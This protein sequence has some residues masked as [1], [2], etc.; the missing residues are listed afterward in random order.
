MA[1][2]L[3]LFGFTVNQAKVY[4]AIVEAGSISV[5]K[6]A[7]NTKL[8]RQDIYKI[9]PDLE[10]KGLVTRSLD[11]P[12]LVKPIS[13][14][15]ALTSLVEMKKK[16]ALDSLA[17]MESNLTEVANAVNM[18]YGT[19]SDPALEE[20][21]FCLLTTEKA[22]TVRADI[23]F[24]KAEKECNVVLSTELLM[25]R[26]HKFLERFEKAASNGATIRLIVETDRQDERIALVVQTVRPRNGNFSAKMMI[27][28]SPKPFSVIDGKEVWIATSKKQENSGVYCVLWSTG[29]NIVGIYQDRFER[30]WKSKN[31]LIIP[32][33]PTSREKEYD[34]KLEDTMNP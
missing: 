1:R 20:E 21:G 32:L 7:E 33:V 34:K 3:L 8:H 13:V 26:R 25:A 29:K 6:I 27:T 30:F 17:F 9:I 11:G 19:E 5:G 22:I 28:E 10:Q 31:A 15:R 16:A 14:R 2:R 24:E 12:L 23:L 18:L 4:L